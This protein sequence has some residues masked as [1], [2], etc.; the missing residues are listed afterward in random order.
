MLGLGES[1]L[2]M[3]HWLTRQGAQVRVADTRAAPPFAAELAR[4][5]PRARLF[6]GAFAPAL[7]EG[8]D[9]L[10]LSPGLSRA[11]PIVIEAQ[12]RG[13]SAHRRDR[14]VRPGAAR[15]V[16]AQ[17]DPILAITGTNGKT[18]VT[19]LV[20]A[21]CR[22]AGLD[23]E[24][25]GNI[26][27]AALSALLRRIGR[28]PMPEVWV[29]ELSSFQLETTATLDAD[30]ATVLNVSDDHLDRYT[31]IDEYAAAK[32]RIFQAAR[33]AG[34]QPRGCARQ[35]IAPARR[36]RADLRPR[37]PRHGR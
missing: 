3:A 27:P 5:A 20:G 6:A 2:A 16:G 10:A 36:K 32:A 12:R 37:P 9:L 26:S 23:T 35:R 15:A 25:A 30:A 7:L 34:A 14:A 4:S 28:G 17:Q 8:I 21:M 18:T 13:D 24:V 19:A 29:L 22:A 33:R 31:G 11:E 1:G